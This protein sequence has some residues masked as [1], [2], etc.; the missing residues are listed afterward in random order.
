MDQSSKKR[1]RLIVIIGIIFLVV[2]AVVLLIVDQVMNKNPYGNYIKIQN[3]DAKVKNISKDYENKITSSLYDIVVLNLNEEIDGTAVEDAFIRESS[4]VQN[5]ATRG[6][7]YSGSFIVDIESLQQS[8]R[9]QYSY[10][11][12]TNDNFVSGYPILLSCVNPQDVKYTDFKCKD[13]TNTETTINTPK[14]SI[15]NF[16]PY[17]TLSYSLRG[18][19]T[20]ESL[21]IHAELRIASVD[22]PTDTNERREVIQTYKNMVTDWIRSK[23]YDPTTYTIEYNYDGNGNL[24]ED[25]AHDHHGEGD[26]EL[27]P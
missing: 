23:G 15:V 21:I 27:V 1:L 24:I 17:S 10:S 2:L 14:D 3:Y 8:Y 6:S 7:R 22:M 25:D 5:E 26:E 9:V 16:L 4:E 19:L 18:D 11:N 20:G 13:L 12:I